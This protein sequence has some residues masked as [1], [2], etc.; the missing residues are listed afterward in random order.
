MKVGIIGNGYVG[1]AVS[2]AFNCKQFVVDPA[3][4]GNTV[5]VLNHWRPDLVF[6]CVP[7]PKGI[8]GGVDGSIVAE[9]LKGLSPGTLVAVKSTVTP[10][11]LHAP[12]LRVVFNPEFL[13]QRTADSDFLAP[14]FMIFGGDKRDC[15]DVLR[16]Y[17]LHSSVQVPDS[18]IITDIKTASLAKYALNSFYATKVMWMNQLHAI[19]AAC[20]CETSWQE[21]ANI[22]TADPRLSPYHMEVPGPDGKYGYGGACFPK[23]TS[24]LLEFAMGHGVYMSILAEAMR[25]NG[26]I[27]S[28]V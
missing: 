4:N 21:F 11:F 14:S 7:T 16:A 23:D 22:L 15:G 2:K 13:T 28:D 9:S 10:A 3:Q 27:R 5:E 25:A 20:G 24:A 26:Q 17:R 12:A 18:T 1:R 6:V 8:D 19:H